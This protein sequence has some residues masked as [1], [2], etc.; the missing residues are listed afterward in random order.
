VRIAGGAEVVDSMIADGCVIPTGA[1]VERSVLSPGV[2][3]APGAVVRE[4]VVLTDTVIEAEAVIEQAIIEK[5]VRIGE[6]ARVGAMQAT[7]LPKIA[8]V[9]KNS[10]VLPSMT[11]EPGGVIG[12]DV[13]ESDYPSLTLVRSDD[14][15]ET[16]RKP[17][18]T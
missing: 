12:P 5:R 10:H 2:R 11:V 18:E 16:K 4:S 1:C 17:Y 15:I 3:L 7:P 8:M 13:V 14:L 6:G 9:G